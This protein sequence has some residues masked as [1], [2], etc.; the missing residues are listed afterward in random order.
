MPL[1]RLYEIVSTASWRTVTLCPM[2]CETSVSAAVAPPRC[3]ASSIALR[4]A[5]ELAGRDRKVAGVRGAGMRGGARAV[6]R[7]RWFGHAQS[8][9]AARL[10]MAV[11]YHSKGPL[12]RLRRRPGHPPGRCP[13]P[14]NRP[15][16][17][18]TARRSRRPRRGASTRCTRCRTWA[19]RWS[20]STPR[21]SP[22]STCRSAWSTR[23][24]RRAA[25]RAH[26]GRRRQMQYIGKLMRDI[27]PVPS[28][29]R[30]SA[31]PSGVPVG[32]RA[33]RGGRAL[34]RATAA[35]RRGGRP[36]RGR[37]SRAPIAPRLPSLV[38]DARAERAR[39]GPPHRYRELFRRM[40]V[41]AKRR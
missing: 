11:G 32:P 6:G 26:E 12:P 14:T 25:I 10:R 29:R 15:R 8:T 23:S 34:A 16:P 41:P 9:G 20:R 28:A 27:D 17:R 39:G 18:A 33:V 4:D 13:D 36:L 35:R 38:R 37:A 31:G 5:L 3:A 24:P 40:E 2:P 21:G 22:S 30:S 19:R 7:D 1:S